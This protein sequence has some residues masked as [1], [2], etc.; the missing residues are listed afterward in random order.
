MKAL[1]RWNALNKEWFCGVNKRNTLSKIKIDQNCGEMR[2]IKMS[3]NLHRILELAFR[4]IS[5]DK[6]LLRLFHRLSTGWAYWAESSE[7]RSPL[8]MKYDC[9]APRSA[10]LHSH[11]LVG[12]YFQA[13]RNIIAPAA[14]LIRQQTSLIV[15]PEWEWWSQALNRKNIE[16]LWSFLSEMLMV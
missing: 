13:L 9:S 2:S 5:L 3:V 8:W 16:S 4:D 6:L 15:T 14:P 11:A 12:D 10:P 1:T 7:R